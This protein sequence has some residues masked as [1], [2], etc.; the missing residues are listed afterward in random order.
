MDPRAH[1]THMVLKKIEITATDFLSKL[2]NVWGY[3]LSMRF[4][5]HSH[6]NISEIELGNTGS[7]HA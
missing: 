6:A 1:P 7:H 2:F 3:V 5:C 4:F